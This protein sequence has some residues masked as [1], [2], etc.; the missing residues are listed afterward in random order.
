MPQAPGV[1][2]WHHTKRE[3]LLLPIAALSL[4][5]GSH[6]SP[7]FDTVAY[8]ML[9]LGKEFLLTSRNVIFYITSIFISLATIVLAGVPAAIY[10][11]LRG[12]QE[13]TGVSL[14]IWLAA[15]ALLT[16]PTLMNLLAED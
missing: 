3:L 12:L 2:T 1:K 4:L 5:N 15:T 14:A 13:S 16:L 7:V 10:E 8:F 9:P 11:R 6:Y